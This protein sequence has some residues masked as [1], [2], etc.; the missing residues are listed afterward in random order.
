MTF[1]TDKRSNRR[2]G[3]TEEE[4]QEERGR[5]TDKKGDQDLA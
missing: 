5:A 4:E 1:K 2:G 3:A